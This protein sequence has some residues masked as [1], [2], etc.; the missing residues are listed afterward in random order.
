MEGQESKN[1]IITGLTRI[2]YFLFGSGVLAHAAFVYGQSYYQGFISIFGFD[3][4]LF[5]ISNFDSYIWAYNSSLVLSVDAFLFGQ[6]YFVY[7][8]LLLAFLAFI[9]LGFW[10]AINRKASAG[11]GFINWLK[12]KHSKLY[13]KLHK[14]VFANHLETFISSLYMAE[15]ACFG[16][17]VITIWIFIPVS[18]FT[19]GEQVAKKRLASYSEQLCSSPRNH[20]DWCIEIDTRNET[21]K[22]RL[23]LKNGDLLGIYTDTGSVVLSMP[24]EFHY[25]RTKLQ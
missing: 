22:G 21:V 14:V 3:Y 9:L 18:G 16:A 19:H 20:W 7:S 6:K 2:A 8:L 12:T 10:K 17:L 1:D 25:Q 5:P 13:A 4:K 11:A 15:L 23:M 24:K